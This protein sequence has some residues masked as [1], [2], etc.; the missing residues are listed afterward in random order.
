MQ[1]TVAEKAP[2]RR[3]QEERRAAMR[4]RL[5]EAALAVLRDE[6]YA[7][8]SV[9]RIVER[10]GVSRGAY[11]HHF[12]AK[13]L[14]LQ[15]VGDRVLRRIYRFAGKVAL[16]SGRKE[17]RLSNLIW[18]IWNDVVRGPEGEVLL[19]LFQAARTD[20]ALAETLRPMAI[21][22][23][24]LFQHAAEYYFEPATPTSPPVSHLIFL[25]QSALSGLLIEAPFVREESFFQSRVQALIDLMGAGV[26]PRDVDGPPPKIAAWDQHD[27]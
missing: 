22:S 27:S 1:S 2:A 10:A 12:P 19:E 26:V 7:S 20:Q 21:R 3:T 18:Y 16:G 8:A 6:G 11:L 24:Q 14:L 5:I 13:D 15:E 4:E 17:E 9:S 23:M 25:V